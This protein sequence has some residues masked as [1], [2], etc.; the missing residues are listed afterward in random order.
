ML[1]GKKTALHLHLGDGEA[2]LAPIERLLRETPLPAALFYPTH[3]NRKRALFDQ[4]C[5][6]GARG[7]TVDITAAG[8]EH[9]HD[10]VDVAVAIE[11]WIRADLPMSAITVSSDA[12]GSV[13]VFDRTGRLESIRAARPGGPLAA[14]RQLLA[15]GWALEAV[16][17]AF[18]LNAARRLGLD[19]KGWLH[20]GADADL[21]VLDDSA[22]PISV[23]A[24]GQWLFR[25]GMVVDRSAVEGAAQDGAAGDGAL[26]VGGSRRTS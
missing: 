22:T 1:A 25:D 9:G 12:G 3:V 15:D 5:A 21:V 11:E 7:M 23:M 20:A 4:A 26:P 24:R 16:L 8:D 17:P 13:P 14:L 6:L 10:E 19:R 18:G 2:G